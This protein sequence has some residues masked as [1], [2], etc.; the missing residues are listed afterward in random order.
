MKYL[1][2]DGQKG[3]GWM[4]FDREETLRRFHRV[5]V[6]EFL[7]RT[8][9]DL[10]APLVVSDIYHNLVAF[11]THQNELGVEDEVEYELVLLQLL[12]GEGNY[13][14][15]ES[16]AARDAVSHHLKTQNPDARI[17]HELAA[18]DVRLN[19]AKAEAVVTDDLGNAEGDVRIPFQTCRWC[20]EDLPQRGE[21]T[22]CPF[23]GSRVDLLPCVACSEGLEPDWRFCIACGT[24]VDRGQSP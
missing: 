3:K 11:H 24:E 10:G 21:V 23:C 6:R 18:A 16:Q 20:G 13:L 8:P 15:I 1:R 7:S 2:N 5:L 9:W 14:V 12:A 4:R 17:F 22:F 19:P